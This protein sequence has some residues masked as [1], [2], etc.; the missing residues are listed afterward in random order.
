[1]ITIVPARLAGVS[2]RI[3]S[4]EVG[5]DADCIITDGDILNYATFVQWAVV[6][7]RMVYDK[8]AEMYYAHI[9]PRPE[10][11]LAPEAKVDPGEGPLEGEK[12]TD[13]ESKEDGSNPPAPEEGSGDSDPEKKDE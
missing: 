1:A 3:G 11:A 6:D 5:K 9:R 10:V 8:Q 2:H 13:A 7:G 4:L 12:G